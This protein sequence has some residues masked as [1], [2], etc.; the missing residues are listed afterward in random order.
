MKKT[1]YDNTIFT[2]KNQWINIKMYL[3]TKLFVI[4]HFNCQSDHHTN[5]KS[6]H[7][8]KDTN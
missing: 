7:I 1:A 2:R 3:F 4:S 5:K 6:G 8:T